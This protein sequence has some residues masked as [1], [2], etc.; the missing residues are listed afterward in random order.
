QARRSS[1]CFLA[2]A[3]PL[4]PPPSPAAPA[5]AV[6]GAVGR[7]DRG[8][9]GGG[10]WS[11]TTRTRVAAGGGWGFTKGVSLP[12]AVFAA[13]RVL[14]GAGFGAVEVAVHAGSAGGGRGGEAT[15]SH[16]RL[17]R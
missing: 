6:S 10:G 13:H 7:T 9:R 8:P 14:A 17:P 3:R 4:P 15:W 2:P 12:V 5:P 16:E 1:P 11:S